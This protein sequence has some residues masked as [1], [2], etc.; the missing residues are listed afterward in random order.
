MHRYSLF[1]LAAVLWFTAAEAEMYRWVDQQGVTH[2]SQVPPVTGEATRLRKPAADP[3]GNS[4]TVER[5]NQQWQQAQDRKEERTEQREQQ[6]EEAQLQARRAEN[7]KAAK[8]NLGILQGPSNRLIKQPGGDYQRL[9]EE[10][11]QAQ[12]SKAEEI[13]ERDCD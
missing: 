13:I 5:I 9:T 12:I 3:V 11:R 2:F 1:A 8:Y 7:C 10:Q 4:D 6:Q